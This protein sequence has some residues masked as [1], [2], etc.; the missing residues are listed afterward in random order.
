MGT[1]DSWIC[2]ATDA[3]T[4]VI[5]G[6]KSGANSALYV[7]VVTVMSGHTSRSDGRKKAYPDN[8]SLPALMSNAGSLSATPPK[9]IIPGSLTSL[10]VFLIELSNSSAIR[11]TCASEP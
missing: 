9:R 3:T 11:A 1:F 10:N 2:V 8:F 6:L 4:A 5:D 7:R